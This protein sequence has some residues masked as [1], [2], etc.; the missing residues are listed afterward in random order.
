MGYCQTNSLLV[1]YPPGIK[2]NPLRCKRWT[3]PECQPRRCAKLKREAKRGNPNTFITLTVNPKVGWDR[4]HRARM[5][6]EAWRRT[7]R[8]AQDEWGNKTIP[9]LAVFEETKAGEPHLHIVCR[10]R[11]IPQDWLSDQM[12]AEL[13]API[14]DIK[15]VK[16]KRQVSSYVAKYVGKGPEKFPGTK[17]YWRSQDWFVQEETPWSD[18]IGERIRSWFSFGRPREIAHDWELIGYE[19]QKFKVGDEWE[20]WLW[21]AEKPPPTPPEEPRKDAS[22]F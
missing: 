4:D 2:I 12:K 17:R 8:K 5:L 19:L 9:F 18:P 21:Q 7:R 20:Y 16:S 14:V 15:R 3:C 10:S 6:V 1:K 22:L 11:W 13:D